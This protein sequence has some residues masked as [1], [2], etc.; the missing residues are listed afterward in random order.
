MTWFRRGRD[1]APPPATSPPEAEPE[2]SPD[3]LRLRLW[4]LVQFIN[5]SAGKLPVE[6]VVA[7]RETTD[8]IREVIET[9][10]D[11]DLDV[12]AVVSINGIVGDYLPTTLRS[13]LALDPAL[14]TRVGPSGRTPR[15]ALREQVGALEAA[16]ADLLEATQAHDV[17][18]L[19][20]QGS[21]LRTKFTRSDLDL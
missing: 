9:S 1:E 13:Y 15:A 8:T 20:T 4:E 10:A 18:A 17:D 19:F 7:A 6:A 11:R 12:Y 21:F 3:T 16:A 14:T 5:R 2:D